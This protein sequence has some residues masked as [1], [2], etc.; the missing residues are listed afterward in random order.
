[1]SN[2]SQGLDRLVFKE[3]EKNHIQLNGKI[4][5]MFELPWQCSPLSS[6]ICVRK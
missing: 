5:L 1:M 2:L 6:L 3:E 4:L